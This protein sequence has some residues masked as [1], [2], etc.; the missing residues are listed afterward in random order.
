MQFFTFKKIFK[1][2]YSHAPQILETIF[3]WEKPTE[4]NKDL[5]HEKE[6]VKKHEQVSQVSEGTVWLRGRL[7]NFRKL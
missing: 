7:L 1:Y 3:Y 2:S 5:I 6:P 4:N